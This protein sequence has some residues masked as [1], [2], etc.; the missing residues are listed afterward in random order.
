MTPATR[1]EV[2]ER[3][4]RETRYD[5]A[6]V[7]SGPD[8]VTG[9]SSQAEFAFEREGERIRYTHDG[10]EDPL[11]YGSLGYGG[12]A[13]SPDDWLSLTHAAPFPYTPVRVFELLENPRAGDVVVVLNAP[14]VMDGPW[15]IAGN[16]QGLTAVEMTVPV[17]VR[18]PDL[19]HLRGRQYIRLEELLPEDGAGLPRP[20]SPGRETH[21]AQLWAPTASDQPLELH[22]EASPRYRTRIGLEAVGRDSH[23]AWGMFDLSSGYLARLWVGVGV[24]GG[25]DSGA[26]LTAEYRFRVRDVGLD[27]QVTSG[28]AP[29]LEFFYR[30]GNHL[31]LRL[32]EFDALGL[33]IRF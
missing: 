1:A 13:L 28:G 4:L 5:F 25:P 16:H 11:G 19:N 17:L 20:R 31:E 30:I 21:T 32:R 27:L 29:D 8:R 6:F 15:S 22:V 10:S 3:V 2:A 18:G 33:A 7:A 12:E 26:F 9:W 14:R 23:R 24:R